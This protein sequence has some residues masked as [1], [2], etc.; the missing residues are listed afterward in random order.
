M[1]VRILQEFEDVEEIR[2]IKGSDGIFDV[3][4]GEDRVFSKKDLGMLAKIDDV[5]EDVI[6]KAILVYDGTIE[7]CAD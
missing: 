1:T 3:H 2:Y 5:S 6:I 7:S 4:V